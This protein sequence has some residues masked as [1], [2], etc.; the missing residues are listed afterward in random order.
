MNVNSDEE[1]VNSLAEN[2]DHFASIGG[3]D[4]CFDLLGEALIIDPN[5]VNALFVRH[6]VDVHFGHFNEANQCLDKI[7][8]KIP[9]NYTIHIAKGKV[10]VRLE[11]YRDAV[12]HFNKAF[13]IEERDIEEMFGDILN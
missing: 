5:N 10:L 4:E 3:W 9:N 11:Q 1:Y 13:E 12:N 2:A 7:L 8:L 6:L